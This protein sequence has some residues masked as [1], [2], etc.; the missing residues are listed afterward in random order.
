M[1]RFLTK[2]FCFFKCI[3]IAF[4]S[5]CKININIDLICYAMTMVLNQVLA[6]LPVNGQKMPFNQGHAE[7]S[8]KILIIHL[9]YCILI[10]FFTLS[11]LCYLFVW[12][13]FYVAV[14]N[15]SVMSRRVFLGWT[16]TKQ[17]LMCLAQGHNTV[18]LAMLKPVTPRSWDKPSTTEPLRS[19]F[20]DYV[21]SH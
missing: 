11:W 3:F 19:H 5:Q 7:I 10:P 16:S 8:S 18:M 4:W 14:N 20:L 12:F 17:G 1:K 15:F 6:K 21:F 2:K 9:F 13:D